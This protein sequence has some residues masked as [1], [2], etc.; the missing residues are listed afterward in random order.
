MGDATNA[1]LFREDESGAMADC[2]LYD[3]SGRTNADASLGAI[4]WDGYE[5]LQRKR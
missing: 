4:F 2:A 5:L 1:S 3:S